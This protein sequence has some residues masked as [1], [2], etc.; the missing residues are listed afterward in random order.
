MQLKELLDSLR[1][2]HDERRI[3][4]DPL[5]FVRR[6]HDPVDR[7]VAGV[8]AS[9]FAY[10]SIGV[11]LRNLSVIFDRIGPS[12]RRFMERLDP[13]RECRHFERFRHRFND[14]RD[15]AALFAA[16]REI[17]EE[18]GSI[19]AFVRSVDDPSSPDVTPTLE[20]FSS[21]MLSTGFGEI[22]GEEGPSKG[23]CFLFPSPSGGSPCKRLCL[24][25]RWMVRPDDGVDLGLWSF[26]GPRR[27]VIPVD[28]HVE[29]IGRLLGLTSRSTPSWRMAREITASL[30][31]LDPDDPVKYDF[32]LAHLGISEGCSGP[33]GP[34]C[35]GCRL[36]VIC[37][38]PRG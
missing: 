38:T 27:L 21:R 23:F 10:G 36:S 28:R 26:I 37:G 33:G 30:A 22:F 14:G 5:S 15:L 16:I 2:G 29:R 20:A 18:W 11:I 13:L 1:G 19:G 9:S 34:S 4:N 3:A 6:F 32:S 24:L 17:L 8:I 35:R 12:P 25:F 7:E 31:R